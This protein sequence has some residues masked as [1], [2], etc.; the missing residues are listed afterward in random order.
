M[1]E[2]TKKLKNLAVR[3]AKVRG[4]YNRD[5]REYVHTADPFDLDMFWGYLEYFAKEIRCRMH[6][7][8]NAVKEAA[9]N[10]MIYIVDRTRHDEH[11]SRWVVCA[12]FLATYELIEGKLAKKCW[13]MPGVEKG[14]D[15][16]GDWTDA[17]P[18]AGRK[19]YEGIMNDDIANYKQVG[20]ALDEHSPGLKD[21]IQ[22]GE[23]YIT[24]ALQ[25]QIIKRFAHAV[26]REES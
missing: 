9:H 25:D 2:P 22:D 24:M 17:L 3:Y 13:D 12:R 16:Y 8:G 26:E 5:V 23:N 1:K 14:D 18:L 21:R 6:Y 15:G 20:K 11:L 10:L 7:S 19:V 4:Q